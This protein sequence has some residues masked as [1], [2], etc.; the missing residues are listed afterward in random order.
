V[1]VKGLVIRNSHILPD[2]KSAFFR[3]SV[4][5]YTTEVENDRGKINEPTTCLNSNC[6]SKNTMSLVHNRCIFSDKQVSR[7]QETT[8]ETPAG[9]TP[10]TVSLCSYDDLVDVSKPGDR[11]EITGIFRAVSVRTNSRRRAVKSLFKTY[12]DV[13]HIKRT[14]KKRMG[15]DS[16]IVNQKE[17]LVDFD[18]G[19]VVRTEVV[20]DEEEMLEMAK[21]HDLYELLARSVGTLLLISAFDLWYGRCQERCALAVVWGKS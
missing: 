9:Q 5:D 2:M 20:E 8:D 10:Y 15:V 19:D 16:S 11:V 12:V 3:C 13:V 1:T 4:C 14:S 21:R 7:L 18:E 17:F 6:K